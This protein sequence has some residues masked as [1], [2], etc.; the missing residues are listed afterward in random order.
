MEL[1]DEKR[2]LEIEKLKREKAKDETIL[3][4]RE[5]VHKYFDKILKGDIAEFLKNM[6]EV[7]TKFDV[8]NQNFINVSEVFKNIAK[9]EAELHTR[10]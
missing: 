5:E 1:A 2:T 8:A 7:S 9:N 3:V 6:E 10:N 4:S